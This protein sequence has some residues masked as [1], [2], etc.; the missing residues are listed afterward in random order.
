VLELFSG[1]L[2]TPVAA[3]SIL[4]GVALLARQ[5]LAHRA[6]T[7]EA[8]PIGW[9]LGIPA[10]ALAML[11]A[12]CQPP[13][14]LWDSEAGGYDALSYHLQL[15]QEWRANHALWPNTHNVFSFLP[16]YV[17]A[18]FLHLAALSGLSLSRCR[19]RWASDCS[20]ARAWA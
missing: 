18:A 9:L 1:F 12:A 19:I 14:W 15:P 4:L 20:R 8:F 7:H 13:G 6:H 17:E 10:L 5:L 3:G 2:A 11:V 16:S